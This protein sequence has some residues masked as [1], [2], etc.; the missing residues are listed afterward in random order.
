MESV[1]RSSNCLSNVFPNIK[2]T[3]VIV[4]EENKMDKATVHMF[5]KRGKVKWRVL[6]KRVNV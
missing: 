2:Q 3:L 1:G 4:L 6:A 5:T